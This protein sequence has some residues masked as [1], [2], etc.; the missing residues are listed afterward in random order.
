MTD[1]RGEP[2]GTVPDE[3]GIAIRPLGDGALV[4]VL[5]DRVDPVLAAR[6][7]AVAARL[8]M[9]RAATPALGRP[10]PAHASVL[11][12]FDPLEIDAE[13]VASLARASASDPEGESPGAPGSPDLAHAVPPTEIR[14]HYGGRDGPDLEA[15]AERHRR[16]P[17]DV[18]ELHAGAEHVVLFLGFGPG[19]AYV[20]GL[21]PELD[22]PR[23][24]TPRE[25]VPAG[26][27]GIAGSLTGLYPSAMPGG[28]QLI[29]RTDDRLFDPRLA[30]PAR[31]RPGAPVRFV[32]AR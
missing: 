19:F 26:S 12:P 8:Q 29:G 9:L 31:L 3:T 10:V 30:D 6:A 24:T 18:I 7:Q 2:A 1:G 5:G 32:A 21:P 11:V 17:A 16:R 25:R 27:V 20:A 28:W 14:V 4:V 13:T 15:V 22:T 23:R